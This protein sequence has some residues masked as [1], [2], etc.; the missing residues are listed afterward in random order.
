MLLLLLLLLCQVTTAR[1]R[2]AKLAHQ[3]QLLRVERD[4]SALA[5]KEVRPA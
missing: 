1:D 2:E 4:R 3:L 5:H